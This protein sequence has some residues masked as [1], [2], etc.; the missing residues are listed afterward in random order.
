MAPF[1][2]DPFWDADLTWNTDSPDLTECFQETVLV[3]TPAAVL[4]LFLPLQAVYIQRSRD[5]GVPWTLLNV[6]RALLTI[7]LV[8][9]AVVDLAYYADED[10]KGSATGK[11]ARTRC[12]LRNLGWVEFDIGCS[13]ASLILLGQMGIW[14][15]L[16][17]QLGNK[18][19]GTSKI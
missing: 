19:G 2:G 18:N 15:E 3:Y 14:T 6:V 1:C 16:A 17:G 10:K 13:T 5:R 12:L 4:F 11:F 9:V 8:I 7:G